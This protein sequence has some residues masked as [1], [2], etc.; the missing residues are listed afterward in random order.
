MGT[1]PQ[2]PR[3]SRRGLASSVSFLLLF[4]FA[5]G[6]G[7]LMALAGGDRAAPAAKPNAGSG[8]RSSSSGSATAVRSVPTAGT[9]NTAR[10]TRDDSV[11]APAA[12]PGGA[13]L[14]GGDI[15]LDFVAAGP[16]TYSH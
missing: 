4:V 14:S 2:S 8:V 3:A 1:S 5:L 16:F 11:A 6:S 13:G 15:G 9:L 12:P 10:A 7:S